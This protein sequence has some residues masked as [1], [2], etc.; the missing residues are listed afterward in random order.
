MSAM[1]TAT[2]DLVPRRGVTRRAVHVA[3]GERQCSAF[4]NSTGERCKATSIIGGFVCAAHGGRSLSVQAEARKR[5]LSFVDPALS[6]LEE[7]LEPSGLPCGVCGR[8]DD[9]QIILS[10]IKLILDRALPAQQK[11]KV[12]HQLDKMGGKATMKDLRRE[13]EEVAGLLAAAPEDV[14]DAE[15]V[16]TAEQI[17]VSAAEDARQATDELIQAQRELAEAEAALA[18]LKKENV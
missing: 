15:I 7:M 6:K 12:K 2:S 17:A 9:R 16:P 10:A 11:V 4:S 18:A 8:N 5:L 13:L 1:T 14:T 3:L